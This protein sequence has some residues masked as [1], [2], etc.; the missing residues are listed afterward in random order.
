MKKKLLI[1]VPVISVILVLVVVVIGLKGCSDSSEE[2]QKPN[3]EPVEEGVT[4]WASDD[5]V[6]WDDAMEDDE[7]HDVVDDDS[8]DVSNKDNV[9]SDKDVTDNNATDNNATD[10]NST[11]DSSS[12]SNPTSGSKPSDDKVT[13]TKKQYTITY[14]VN[15]KNATMET[16]TQTVTYGEAFTLFTPKTV[17]GDDFRFVKWIIT[18]TTTEF[19]SGIYAVEGDITLTAVWEDTYSKNY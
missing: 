7:E 16:T 2:T 1:I 9:K 3:S 4:D 5:A 17:A 14:I 12:E 8:A 15:N 19:K 18:G 11:D 10:D 6:N 13:D